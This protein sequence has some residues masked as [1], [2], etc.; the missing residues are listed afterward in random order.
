VKFSIAV[1]GSVTSVE[2]AKSSGNG[3]L[4]ELAVAAVRRTK[5]RTPPQGLTSAKRF[6]ELPY[7]FR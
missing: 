3:K 7:Y 5:F 6:Y 2:V 1:D 4:D